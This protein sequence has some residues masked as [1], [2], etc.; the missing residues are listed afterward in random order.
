MAEKDLLDEVQEALN[1]RKGEW[2]QIAKAVQGVSYSWVSQV[3][4]GKYGSA[5]TY[6]R[7]KAVADYLEMTKKAA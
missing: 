5:P 1:A 7:L 4:R 2:R 6:S 3:G